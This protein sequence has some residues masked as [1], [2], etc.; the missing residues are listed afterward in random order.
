MCVDLTVAL[1]LLVDLG[2]TLVAGGVTVGVFRRTE[3]TSD[4]LA[5]VGGL[6]AVAVSVLLTAGLSQRRVG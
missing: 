6:V 1:L 5:A 4:R 3:R 2:V